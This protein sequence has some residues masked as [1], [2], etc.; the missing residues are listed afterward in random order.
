MDNKKNINSNRYESWEKKKF[1]IACDIDGTLVNK[2]GNLSKKTITDLKY[3]TSLGHII[4]LITGRPTQGSI[5]LYEKLGLKTIMCN[6][7]GSYISNPSNKNFRPIVITFSK[8]ILLRLFANKNLMKYVNNSLIEGVNKGWL[9]RKPDNNMSIKQMMEMF[10][11][12]NRD[13]SIIKNDLKKINTDICS[14]LLHI[15]NLE[16]I[17]S[18]I[19]EV[20]R[21]AP[22]LTIRTWSLPSEGVII[23]I[24]G[25]FA[26]KENALEFLSSYYGIPLEQCISFGDGDND[27]GM[28]SRAVWGFALKNATPAARLAAR[29]MTKYDNNNDGVVRE[30]RKFLKI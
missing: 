1:L 11:L 21:I 2:E 6:Q 22:T 12:V 20:K 27:V 26:S 16:N 24:N 10:H 5:K 25:T 15:N 13:I 7:N 18:I 29:F 19:Y 3:I 30:L 8:E 23:E 4:C 9:L 14:I 17:N 28:L